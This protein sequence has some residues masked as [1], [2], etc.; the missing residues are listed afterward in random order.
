MRAPYTGE[1]LGAIPACGE[2]DVE[3]AVS[4]ARAA[5]AAW[6][7]LPFRQRARI[8]LRFHDL[9]FERQDELLD[10]IQLENGKSRANAFEEILDTASVARYYALRA[11]KLLRPRRRKGALP[12]LTKT[13]E[14]RAPLGVLGIVVPWN[15]PLNLAVTDAIPALLA[16]NTV[17]LKPDHQVSF[18]ALWAVELLREAG[19]PRDVLTAVTGDGRLVG[20][21]IGARTDAMMFTGSTPT[22]RAVARQAA[23]RLIPF[24][25]ELGGKNPMLVLEDA[26]LDRTVPGAIRGCFAGAGQVCVS[27]ERIYIHQSRFEEFRDRFVAATRA[28]RLGAAFDYSIDIGSLTN[29]RQLAIVED[30]VADALGKGARLLAGGKRRPDLGPLFYEPTIL[31]DVREDMK[32]YAEETFGPVVALYPF[33]TEAEAIE[34]AN[35]TRFGLNASIWTRNTGRGLRLARQIQSGS[36]NINEAYAATWGSVDSPF[37]GWKHS[38]PGVRHGAEGILVYTVPQ[39]IA[40][41]RLLPIAPPFG[42]DPGTHARLMGLL[43]KVLRHIPFLR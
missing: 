23:E 11:G 37:G 42:M 19:L 26:D 32:L 27:F 14:Y 3:L 24:I 4:R 22:G 33:A 41:E 13:F 2:A 21:L 10:I 18:T 25:L 17:V 12:G 43:L 15:F 8:F 5:L 38:G 39:T 35:N 30:H 31:T 6:S 1:T 34:R 20:P 29:E 16:G 40:V 9:V 28:L 7:A 36:V